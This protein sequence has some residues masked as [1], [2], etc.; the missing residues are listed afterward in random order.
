MRATQSAP[1]RSP[2]DLARKVPA[3]EAPAGDARQV[4]GRRELAVLLER[5]AQNRLELGDA[6]GARDTRVELALGGAAREALVGAGREPRLE[7]LT[8]VRLADVND[9]RRARLPC[10]QLAY[11]LEAVGEDDRT[12]CGGEGLERLARRAGAVHVEHVGRYAPLDLRAQQRVRE[13]QQRPRR[14]HHAHHDGHGSRRFFVTRPRLLG[15]PLEDSLDDRGM[16]TGRHR[17]S[18]CLE[19]SE[20]EDY[21]LRGQNTR[22]P[23]VTL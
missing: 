11:E 7:P 23:P 20:R 16:S 3:E 21:R 4:V 18:Q 17:P 19:S 13:G 2:L 6:P 22:V 12:E 10:T 15:A 1:R 8:G 14:G 5:D 9:E